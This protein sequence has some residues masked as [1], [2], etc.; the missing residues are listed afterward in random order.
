MARW[1]KTHDIPL[2]PRGGRSHNQI[3]ITLDQANSAPSVLR[4]ALT[5]HGAWDRL[6]RFADAVS[7]P[8]ITIAAQALG[9]HQGALTSQINRL[10]RELG[11]PLYIC[12]ERGHPMRLTPLGQKVLTAITSL[13][14]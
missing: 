1:A 8:A 2:R 6:H 10:E 7:H 12:A 5:G 4:P 14:S 3:R 13:K 11:G 9:L